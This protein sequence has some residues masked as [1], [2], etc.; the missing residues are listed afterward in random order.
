MVNGTSVM[1]HGLKILNL[2]WKALQPMYSFMLCND[3]SESKKTTQ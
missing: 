1:I 2:I 3:L